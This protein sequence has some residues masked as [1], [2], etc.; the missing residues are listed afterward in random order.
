[1]NKENFNDNEYETAKLLEKQ[2]NRNVIE[3]D[4]VNV[5]N[6]GNRSYVALM[7]EYAN[8]GVSFLFFFYLFITSF[9]ICMN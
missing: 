2:K 8:A 9:F 4:C 3:Y 6:V 5:V 7:L 1:M